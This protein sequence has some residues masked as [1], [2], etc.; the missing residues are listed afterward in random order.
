MRDGRGSGEKGTKGL[1]YLTLAYAAAALLSSLAGGPDLVTLGPVTAVAAGASLLYALAVHIAAVRRKE[2]D[3][4]RSE[5]ACLVIAVAVTV[6]D[7]AGDLRKRGADRVCRPPGDPS[8]RPEP[9]ADH[10]HHIYAES[11]GITRS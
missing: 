10:P 2:G 4:I 11:A 7:A 1:F 9:A 6:A 8:V 5:L 3:H